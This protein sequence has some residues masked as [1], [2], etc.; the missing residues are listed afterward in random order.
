MKFYYGDQ[1]IGYG[2]TLN[3]STLISL[4]DSKKKYNSKHMGFLNGEATLTFENPKMDS[5]ALAQLLGLQIIENIHM[6]DT[7]QNKTHRTK[8]INKKY[9]KKYGFTNIP[10]KNVFMADGKL[11]GHPETLKI[12]RNEANKR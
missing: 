3:A 10:K 11:I 9:I 12:L 6:V 4:V 1:E 8:R 5:F 2:S 7:I